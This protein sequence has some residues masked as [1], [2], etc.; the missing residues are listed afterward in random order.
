MNWYALTAPFYETIFVNPISRH[1]RNLAVEALQLRPGLT[2]LDLACGTGMNFANIIAGIGPQ[3]TL[4]G[5]DYSAEML[6]QAQQRIARSGWGNVHLLQ[7]DAAQLSRPALISLTGKP[8]LK[9]DRVL[10]TLG[11]SVIPEWERAFE[12][13]FELLASGG[14]Y[15][16]MDYF[17][18]RRTL[19]TQMTA[20]LLHADATRRFWEPLERRC[21]DYTEVNVMPSIFKDWPNAGAAII[22]SGTK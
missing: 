1:H 21:R 18:E 12:R 20:A 5:T 17:F 2:V 10:C 22:A 14:R 3:G 7:A 16:I 15:V 9:I 19:Y 13:S 8:D 11:M 4:I 6:A